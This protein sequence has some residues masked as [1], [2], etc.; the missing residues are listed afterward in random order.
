MGKILINRHNFD[1]ALRKIDRFLEKSPSDPSFDRVEVDGGLF[2]WGDHKVTGSEMNNFINKVQEK[3]GSVN[4]SLRSIFNEFREVYNAFNFLDGEYIKGIVGAVESAEEAS[5]QALNAQS[6]IKTTVDKLKKTV[7]GLVNLKKTVSDLDETVRTSYDDITRKLDANYQIKKIP[8]IANKVS[9]LETKCTSLQR[10]QDDIDA[11]V[12]EVKK[13]IDSQKKR[14]DELNNIYSTLSSK[15]HYK[16]IDTI[17]GDVE[18][19]KTRLESIDNDIA[20]FKQYRSS[21]QAYKHL[22]DIDAIWSDVEGHKTRL[23]NID[24]DITDFK[25]YRSSLQAYKHLGDVDAIWGDVEGHKTRLENIDKDIADFKQYRSSLQAYK[26][27]GDIDAIWNDVEGHKQEIND[28]KG[29]IK[30]THTRIKIAY[31]IAGGSIALTIGL[32]VLQWFGA[33]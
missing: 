16:D 8:N 21:L 19:H 32:F 9:T 33:L 14:N 24:N 20:D 28:L 13:I 12:K 18:G 23:E 25:Q 7:E 3:L 15:L 1:S 10:T 31:G 30:E 2:G 22:G 29:F 27:L 17:W 11:S 5:K 6:D 4:T 26:H